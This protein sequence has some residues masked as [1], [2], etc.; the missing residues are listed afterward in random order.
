[1]RLAFEDRDWQK[2]CDFARVGGPPSS[3]P[4]NLQALSEAVPPPG[5]TVLVID[6]DSG[7]QAIVLAMLEAAG[8][9]AEACNSAEEAL[10]KLRE[11]SVDLIILDRNLNGMNGIELC[12]RLRR[13]TRHGS[14]PILFLSAMSTDTEL[15]EAFEAGADDFVSKPF[16][17]HE[18]GARVL[19]L[20]CRSK[21]VRV[22]VQTSP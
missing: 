7:V 4:E 9:R 18:L 21:A 1:M 8:Y 16:R 5:S 17:A 15:R 19:G 14:L 13:D 22:D 10:D 3:R 20:I 11:Q 6:D 12:R 2:L